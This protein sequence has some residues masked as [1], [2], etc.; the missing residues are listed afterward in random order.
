[1]DDVYD[2]RGPGVCGAEN[3]C[4]DGE[5]EVEV[6]CDLDDGHEDDHIDNERG[7]EWPQATGAA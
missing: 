3:C 6:V 2:W 1:M 7:F 5:N 4:F